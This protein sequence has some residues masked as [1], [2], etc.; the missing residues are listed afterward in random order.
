MLQTFVHAKSPRLHLVRKE[1]DD[2]QNMR[3]LLHNTAPRYRIDGFVLTPTRLG[4]RSGRDEN[5]LKFKTDHPID[6]L[7]VAEDNGYGLY[8]DDDGSVVRLA[9]VVG[10]PVFFDAGA[11]PEFR[12]IEQG[13]SVY[14]REIVQGASA[15]RHVV[16]M[17][18][19]FR[20]DPSRGQ[21]LHLTFLRFRPD[22]DGPNNAQ[23][24]ARTIRTI[25][26]NVQLS[27]VYA[28]IARHQPNQSSQP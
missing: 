5:L 14:S 7:L 2:A 21:V 10:I 8:V 24:V 3:G 22:K 12:Q 4:V 9:D 6:V 20:D 18:C 16:E 13:A 1:H 15:F 26:D 28:A 27:D 11:N 17:D 23:T 19:A 25:Q